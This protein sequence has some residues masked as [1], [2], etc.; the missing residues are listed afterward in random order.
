MFGTGTITLYAGHPDAVPTPASKKHPKAAR[1]RP[2]ASLSKHHSLSPSDPLLFMEQLSSAAISD[3]L[4][5]SADSPPSPPRLRQLARPMKR[6]S[7]SQRQ[8][9][10]RTASSESS[11][12]SSLTF[13]DRGPLE[14]ALD[15]PSLIRRSSIHSNDYNTPSRDRP[16]SIPNFGRG[17]FHRRG[18]SNRESSAHASTDAEY[19]GDV[20]GG[21]NSAVGAKE[22]IL[23]S[24]FFRRKASS[25][26]T[27]PKRPHISHPF[28]FQHVAHKQNDN[29]RI[30][31]SP[32][33][34]LKGP[35]GI[36]T[37]EAG[38]PSRDIHRSLSQESLSTHNV[39]FGTGNNPRP[40]LVPRHTAPSP[41]HRRGLK[42]IRSQE[43]LANNQP[44]APPRP[45]RSP[46]Q[47]LGDL[48]SFALPLPPRTSSRQSLLNHRDVSTTL[49]SVV[50]TDSMMWR[51]VA[52]QQSPLSPTFPGERLT[53][54][55]AS[56]EPMSR[57]AQAEQQ[58][59]STDENRSSSVM[60]AT[61]DASWPLC[62]T[63]LPDVPEEDEH[64]GL[65]RRSRL[66]VAS[67][68]SS[69]RGIQSVPVLRHLAESHHHR[70]MSGAS[71][72][73]GN[74]GIMGM[75]RLTGAAA[76]IPSSLCSPTRESWEDLI[77]YCY[78][79]EAE[80]NCD[81]QW[82]RPSLDISRESVTPPGT[83]P[84]AGFQ[85][86]PDSDSNTACSPA[87]RQASFLPTTSQVPS[88]SPA[89]NTS[90]TQFEAE[91]TTPHSVSFNTFPLS[92]GD[93]E[94]LT[95]ID[96]E[97][98]KR[99]SGYSTSQEPTPCHPS[100]SSLIPCDC[101]QESLGHDADKQAY[102]NDCECLVGHCHQSTAF[103]NDAELSLG[104]NTSFPLADQR[105]ST[106]T[107]ASDSTSRSHSAGRQY[108]SNNSS[109]STLTRR[110]A[111][112]SSLSNMAGTLTDDSKPPPTTQSV[113]A[114][115]EETKGVSSTSHASQDCVPDMSA[116]PLPSRPNRSHH[117][118]H[119]SES[120]VRNESGPLVPVESSRPARLRAQTTHLTTQS[121]PP[122]GQYA[123][124]PR[125]YVKATG[126][127][128]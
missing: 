23:P 118:S 65:S 48:S 43:Q 89:S 68:H 28:N 4:G 27:A 34:S 104:N 58:Y 119:A 61:R 36:S 29:A 32:L 121:P 98:F 19:S 5:S 41:G 12:I 63:A 14:S 100:P 39:G 15:N 84:Q 115:E 38:V 1:A 6:I 107:T 7:Y 114:V 122:V 96:S 45:P 71:D 13:S 49:D 69:L 126:D 75:K 18:K 70:Q 37:S 86:G 93:G 56:L 92:R 9:G 128:I 77:D 11:S 124:Y 117:K 55:P 35:T 21:N 3:F 50:N 53:E 120:Q 103:Y 106:S 112:S 22:S 81:Y 113:D 108:R 17:F 10:H 47:Q 78:E 40:P 42:Q 2:F 95:S 26:E 80:A 46:T 25:D 109:R 79:H 83:A 51:N 8:H 101:Q 54:E 116:F 30:R 44:Q 125:Q 110:T 102:N 90:S 16:E 57:T 111:S 33:V 20:T 91:A 59:P 67:N 60:T 127:H 123:L 97:E 94:D 66:S 24:I 64:H 76:H 99:S 52:Y 105:I 82:D 62:D 87:R 85:F 88:L 73:L 31:A 72:T 74:L